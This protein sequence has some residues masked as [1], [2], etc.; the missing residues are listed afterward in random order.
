MTDEEFYK[1][2]VESTRVLKKYFA[3]VDYKQGVPV[4]RFPEPYDG[5]GCA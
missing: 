4:D 1:T 2:V 5:L 3:M